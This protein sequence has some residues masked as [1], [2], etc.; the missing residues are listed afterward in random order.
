[1]A[2]SLE[3]RAPFLDYRLVEL[4]ASMPANLKFHDGQTKYLFRETVK[5]LLPNEISQRKKKGFSMP[6]QTGIDS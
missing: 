5:H 3:V 2:N 6:I 4:V 1:M